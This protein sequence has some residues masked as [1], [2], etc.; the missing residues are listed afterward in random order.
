MNICV[1]GCGY[2]GSRAAA[3]WKEIEHVVTVTT[4]NPGRI[5]ELEKFADHV[6]ITDS[7]GTAIEGQDVILI[8]VAP[9]PEGDYKNTYLDTA[10]EILA[11]IKPRQKILYTGSTS[12]YGDHEGK[13]VDEST[14]LKPPN[15]KAR[16][17]AETEKELLKHPNTCI[18]RLGEILGPERAI[19]ERLKRVAGKEL[20]GTGE[21]PTN[22]IHVDDI[23]KALDFAI[24]KNLKGIY[25]LC[26]DEHIPRKK[27]YTD[28]CEKEGIPLPVWNPSRKSV[29]GGSRIV[30]NRK[31]KNAG[32]SGFKNNLFTSLSSF[33][34]P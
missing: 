2:V 18:F 10:K 5:A 22:V 32:F 27:L 25:N 33:F 7:P 11:V 6:I 24:E 16:V 26:N 4:R 31:I 12:V 28:I 9:G 1:I 20:P 29:H 13:V 14:P 23:V 21:N 8:A 34:N 19:K 15:D 30:S 17:L 3:N